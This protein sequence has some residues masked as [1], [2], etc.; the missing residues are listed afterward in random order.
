MKTARRS[1]IKGSVLAGL[2]AVASPFVSLFS[3]PVHPSSLSSGT[4]KV[5]QD[6]LAGG[7][8]RP[9]GGACVCLPPQEWFT[10]GDWV[11]QKTLELLQ[12]DHWH[13]WG[14]WPEHG[15]PNRIPMI[16]ATRYFDHDRVRRR[17]TAN[18]GEVWMNVNEPEMPL[19][20]NETPEA[21]ADLTCKLIEIGQSANT[22]WQWGSPAVTLTT[23]YNGLA[24]LTEWIKIMRRRRGI[25]MPFTFFI[26]PYT[27]NTV[28]RLRDSM[29][30]WWKWYAVWGGKTPVVISEVC[31]E[32]APVDVQKDVMDECYKMLHA[33]DVRGVF[34]FATYRSSVEEQKRQKR[35]PWQHY[36][37]CELHHETQAVT[38]TELGR[39][40]KG[41]Q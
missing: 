4:T 22:E 20:C 26:H 41:L 24:W 14:D 39:H 6:E 34:W 33:G 29:A 35:I 32:D 19:Q 23:E 9:Y 11:M 28:Q 21:I 7:F 10:H 3:E 5:D 13:S 27:C 1:F 36:P 12:P 38:L 40:W 2:G 18:S 17:M 30:A 37:L 31:A 16:F 25:S 8:T 15:A